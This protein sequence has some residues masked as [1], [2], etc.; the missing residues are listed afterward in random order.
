[1]QSFCSLETGLQITNNKRKLIDASKRAAES[2]GFAENWGGRLVWKWVRRWVDARELLMLKRGSHAKT[3][4]LL[5]DPAIC[6][7][8]RSYVHSNKWAIDPAKFAQFGQEKMVPAAAKK[9]LEHI[10]RTEMPAGLK[11]Y[12]DL[13]LFPHI[14]MKVGRGISMSTV[15]RMLMQEGFKY[16]EHK[17]LLYYDGHECPDV[18]KYHQ[19]QFL[20]AMEDHHKRMVEYVV[21]NMEE[22]LEKKPANYV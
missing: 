10:I 14:H 13:E 21:N 6:A 15:H 5:S 20:P 7:K 3:F 12:L 16:T 8:V 9:F 17:K 11:K 22:E 4:S 2:Q 18:V 1:M 19:E